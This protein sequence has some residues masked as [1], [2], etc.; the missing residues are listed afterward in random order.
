MV[1][2]CNR[3]RIGLSDSGSDDDYEMMRCVGVD[4][5][6]AMLGQINLVSYVP[7][8]LWRVVAS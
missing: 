5:V 6:S 8:H 4:I 7:E 2:S 1:W 3:F